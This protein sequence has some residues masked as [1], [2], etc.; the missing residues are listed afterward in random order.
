MKFVEEN[1]DALLL[2]KANDSTI[3]SGDFDAQ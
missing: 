1:I 2:V 3:F